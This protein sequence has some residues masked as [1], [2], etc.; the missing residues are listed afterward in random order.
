MESSVSIEQRLWSK[1]Q[2]EGPNECWEWQAGKNKL[3]YGQIKIDYN[4]YPAHKIA[5]QLTFGPVPKNLFVCHECDNPGCCNPNHLFLGTPKQNTQDSIRK[6]RWVNPPLQNK[7]TKRKV[8]II[9]ALLKKGS[10]ETDIANLFNVC[11][12]TINNIKNNKTWKS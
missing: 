9:R 12:K 10:K 8:A 6:D 4:T 5:Y 11:R 2:K 7:L 1:V 3:G